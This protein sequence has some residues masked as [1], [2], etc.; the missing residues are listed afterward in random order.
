MTITIGNRTIA[1]ARFLNR[2]RAWAWADSEPGQ[3]VV[4]GEAPE[5]WVVSRRDGSILEKAGYE[6][7]ERPAGVGR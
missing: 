2:L 4:L 1:P 3:V 7:D 5:F 6:L